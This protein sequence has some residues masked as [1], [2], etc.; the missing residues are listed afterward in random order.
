MIDS[1]L[2]DSRAD[3][4][5]RFLDKSVCNVW[6]VD[7]A[8]RELDANGFTRLDMR[9]AWDIA[10]GGRY[11]VIKNST[12]IIAFIAGNGSAAD[13]YR[14]IAAHSDS[15]GFR[16]KPHPEMLVDGNILKLNTEVY[17]GP[18]LYTWFDRPLSIAGKV[19][20]RGDDP[21][22]PAVRLVRIER[23]VLTIPHLAIHYNRQ[24]NDGNPLSRQ[25]DML[26]VIAMLDDKV[27]ANDFVLNLV[28]RELGV[29]KTDIIDCD[30]S[31]YD[32]T[33]A[34]RVGADGEFMTSGRI[35]D[36]SMVH[37]ALTAIT[38]TA[39]MPCP[40]TRVM[41]IFDNEETGSG[42]KQGAASP[43]LYN[44]LSRINGSLGGDGE[45]LVRAIDASFMVSA[46][47]A[48]GTHPNYPEKQDPTNHPVLG[49][50]PVIKI[51]ANCKYMTD[52]ESAAVFVSV[53]ERAGVPYQ[54]FVNH[55]DV[56]GG[57]TLGNILTSQL[58]LRGVDMGAAQW[59]MHSVR[60]TSSVID[61]AYIIEAFS[62][63]FSL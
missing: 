43:L 28:A 14:I 25:K 33:K 44:I 49:G 2:I 16:I 46:D 62:T 35:D 4:L 21:L 41:A 51:N 3:A 15:P 30:L 63:F 38:E 37:A 60:E 1:K 12:A 18:I 26:P 27:K 57:S 13:G 32:T 22:N 5:M 19:V 6:A 45:T 53:C 55:S 42:T 52:A 24:V 9:R 29:D 7:T 56:A 11:Y 48:H 10:P 8:A 58:E 54:Y 31:L 39:D 47:N 20:L 40:M 59:A 34:C 50:G 23:P 17:G 61:H 36:L